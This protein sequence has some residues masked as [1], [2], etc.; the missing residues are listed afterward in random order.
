MRFE[1]GSVDDTI[2]PC[3]TTQ[4]TLVVTTLAPGSPDNGDMEIWTPT[5]RMLLKPFVCAH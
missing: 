5:L 1:E 3:M 4:G 2:N